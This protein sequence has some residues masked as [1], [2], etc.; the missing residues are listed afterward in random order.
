M[1][2]VLWHKRSWSLMRGQDSGDLVAVEEVWKT[3]TLK[4]VA[5]PMGGGVMHLSYASPDP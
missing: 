5:L 1:G 2:W 4:S 3:W